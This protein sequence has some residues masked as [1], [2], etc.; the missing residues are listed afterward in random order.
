LRLIADASAVDSRSFVV[1]FFVAADGRARARI[2]DARS[3][4]Q[5]LI[6]EPEALRALERALVNQQHT[7]KERQ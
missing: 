4:R 1:R 5:W 7:D 3:T 2:T 6:A